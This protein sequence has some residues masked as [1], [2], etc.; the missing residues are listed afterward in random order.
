MAA[1]REQHCSVHAL[2]ITVVDL[3]VWRERLRCLRMVVAP[4]L[5]ERRIRAIA[6]PD[7]ELLRLLQTLK[8]HN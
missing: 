1:K 5:Y 2:M 7:I 8:A 4:P 6:A 3:T